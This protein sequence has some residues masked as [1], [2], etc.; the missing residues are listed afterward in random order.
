MDFT[1]APRNIPL[2]R[3]ES[4][5]GLQSDHSQTDRASPNV[6]LLLRSYHGEGLSL[7]GLPRLVY[8]VV[9]GQ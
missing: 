3:I 2:T 4:F 5:V 1:R 7:T 8:N 9:A 6:T